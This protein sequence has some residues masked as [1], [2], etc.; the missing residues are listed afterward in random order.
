M[1]QMDIMALYG[2]FRNHAWVKHREFIKTSPVKRPLAEKFYSNP[3][4]PRRDGTPSRAK[5]T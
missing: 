5:I 4:Q 1:G 3:K 2:G